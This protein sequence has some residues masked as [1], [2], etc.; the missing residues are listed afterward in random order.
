[1]RNMSKSLEQYKSSYKHK[2]IILDGDVDPEWIESMNSV[3]DDNK[4]LTLVNNER[5]SMS[6]N[7]RILIEVSNL[8]QATPAT[9]SRGG[10]LY[11]NETDIG[12]K[13][14]M[15]SWIEKTREQFDEYANSVFYL[16]FTQ[17]LG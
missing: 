12:W 8:K 10:V 15:E 13:P 4:L 3:M 6:P 16:N 11:V 14:F 5:I 2:F 1:M 9:V 17:N 7:M